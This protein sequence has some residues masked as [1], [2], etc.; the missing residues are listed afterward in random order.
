MLTQ[1]PGSKELV[2]PKS[3]KA[4]A[5]KVGHGWLWPWQKLW[6]PHKLLPRKQSHIWAIVQCCLAQPEVVGCHHLRVSF[7]RLV[8]CPYSLFSGFHVFKL[9]LVLFETKTCSVCTSHSVSDVNTLFQFSRLHST[10]IALSSFG[11]S[12]G[13]YNQ[14][15]FDI[16]GI[17]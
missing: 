1:E 15:G 8:R 6:C 7:T 17:A 14:V 13:V 5:M 10:L 4:L 9:F 16:A 2:F 3:P 12:L 11:G